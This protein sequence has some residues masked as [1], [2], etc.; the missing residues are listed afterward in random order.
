[1][2]YSKAEIEQ[3]K[4][5]LLRLVKSG[6]T[7]YTVLRSCARS[8]MSRRIDL[9]VIDGSPEMQEL[10]GGKPR[11]QY[12]SGYAAVVMGRPRPPT[13]KPGIEIKG[14]GMDMG[15]AL[16]DDLRAALFGWTKTKTGIRANGELRQEWI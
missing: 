14:C 3:A 5:G 16:V 15:F 12:L 8:G 6:D 13:G 1:M 10:N 7:V 4:A 11:L 9:Y 2:K